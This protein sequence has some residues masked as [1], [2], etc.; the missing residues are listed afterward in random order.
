MNQSLEN[1][2]LLD[3][4]DN[5]YYFNGHILLLQKTMLSLRK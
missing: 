2:I 4:L 3:D 5:S 1:N